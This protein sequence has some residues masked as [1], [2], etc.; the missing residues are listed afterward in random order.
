L[1]ILGV[2]NRCL[3]DENV[4]SGALEFLKFALASNFRFPLNREQ[5]LM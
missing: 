2:L 3:T 5:T 1:V 4:V